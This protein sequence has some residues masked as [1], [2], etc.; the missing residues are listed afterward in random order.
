MGVVVSDMAWFLV[1]R[2]HS[3]GAIVPRMLR[4][5]QAAR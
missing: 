5:A 1:E 2:S 4:S 3:L